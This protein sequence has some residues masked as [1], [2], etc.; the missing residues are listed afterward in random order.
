M[1]LQIFFLLSNKELENNLIF[2]YRYIIIKKGKLWQMEDNNIKNIVNKAINK[3]EYKNLS[4]EK[5]I[6]KFLQESSLFSDDYFI[7]LMTDHT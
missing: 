3:D 5:K 2:S 6:E 1:E 7:I 4:Y